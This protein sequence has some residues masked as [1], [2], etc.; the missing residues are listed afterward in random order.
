MQRAIL[1]QLHTIHVGEPK[2]RR[3]TLFILDVTFELQDL[4]DPITNLR[5]INCVYAQPR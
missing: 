2:L 1:I 5:A 4:G 3:R